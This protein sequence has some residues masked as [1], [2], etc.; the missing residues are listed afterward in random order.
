[1]ASTVKCASCHESRDRNAGSVIGELK[2]VTNKTRQ[3]AITKTFGNRCPLL[4]RFDRQ[5]PGCQT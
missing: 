2:P 5:P 4:R 3:A 1:M